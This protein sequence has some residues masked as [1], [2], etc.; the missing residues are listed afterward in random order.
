MEWKAIALKWELT[1][2]ILKIVATALFVN[3]KMIL[4]IAKIV[5]FKTKK[6]KIFLTLVE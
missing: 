5:S 2:I 4:S 3:T 6:E 1:A